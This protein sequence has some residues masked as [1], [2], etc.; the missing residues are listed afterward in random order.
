LLASHRDILANT[1]LA[2]VIPEL[3]AAYPAH[4]PKTGLADPAQSMFAAVKLRTTEAPGRLLF[5]QSVPCLGASVL[6]DYALLKTPEIK[7]CA[8]S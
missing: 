3:A 4:Y 7:V 2:Q 1:R 5:R 6:P 8:A